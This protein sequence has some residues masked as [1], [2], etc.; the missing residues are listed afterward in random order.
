MAAGWTNTPVNTEQDLAWLGH[1]SCVRVW[2]IYL[3][4]FWE[5]GPAHLENANTHCTHVK[6]TFT[7]ADKYVEAATAARS[8]MP[9]STVTKAVRH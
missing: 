3:D 4:G 1:V 2:F 8:F 7:T 5:T 6:V 9:Q